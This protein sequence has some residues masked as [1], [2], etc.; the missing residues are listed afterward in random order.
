M[1]DTP[2]YNDVARLIIN[3]YIY[4][5]ACS[6]TSSHFA[7]CIYLQQGGYI[8]VSQGRTK[9]VTERQ[10]TGHLHS[11]IVI[12]TVI[13]GVGDGVDWVVDEADWV[14]DEADWVGDGRLWIADSNLSYFP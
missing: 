4:I 14:G 5:Y 12:G 8:V 1:L 2:L 11:Y 13:K 9:C 3:V 7:Q 6:R 10:V